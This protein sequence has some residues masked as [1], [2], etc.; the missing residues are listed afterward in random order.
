MLLM[1]LSIY[2]YQ[3]ESR[4]EIILRPAYFLPNLFYLCNKIVK[5]LPG[6]VP[7][8]HAEVALRNLLLVFYRA[9]KGA[10]QSVVVG[11]QKSPI[12]VKE[13]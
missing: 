1:F 4:A 10:D 5:L 9:T 11:N 3:D 8:V 7:A 12:W 13:I 2:Y 6:V